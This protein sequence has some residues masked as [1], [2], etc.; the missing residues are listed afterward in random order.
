MKSKKQESPVKN[1]RLDGYV[2]VGVATSQVVSLRVLA[3]ISKMLS[4]YL[5]QSL[6]PTTFHSLM[7]RKG[8]FTLQPC[9]RIDGL[10][11]KHLLVTPIS[12]N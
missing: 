10:L 5:L 8:Q 9:T 7:C 3:R 6:V 4:T 11:G 2:M 12:Q 1:R